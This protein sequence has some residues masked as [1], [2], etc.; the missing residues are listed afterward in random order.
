[1]TR[2]WRSP[3]R[4]AAYLL[5]AAL[6]SGAAATPR[7]TSARARFLRE[8]GYPHGRPGWIVDHVIPLARGGCDCSANLQW[9]TVEAARCK[10]AF[11]LWVPPAVLKAH[12]RRG[13]M[14]P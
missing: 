2:T 1:M 12:Y 14:A 4:L 3:A 9:Q 11:E 6:L 10:D 8:T 5:C 7:T 13:Q